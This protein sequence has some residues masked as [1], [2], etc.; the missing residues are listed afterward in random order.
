[1]LSKDL[2][3]HLTLLLKMALTDGLPSCILYIFII[4]YIFI[5][6]SPSSLPLSLSLPA[7]PR[8]CGRYYF[9]ETCLYIQLE[10]EKETERQR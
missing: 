6:P 3:E 1:M 7:S 4:V 10:K 5:F 8:C 2:V 9:E